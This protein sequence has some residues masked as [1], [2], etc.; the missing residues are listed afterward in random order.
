MT[1]QGD[2]SLTASQHAVLSLSWT[3]EEHAYQG[4]DSS[5]VHTDYRAVRQNLLDIS[6]KAYL[7][8]HNF[9]IC[10]IVLPNLENDWYYLFGYL[11][12]GL[13]IVWFS[14]ALLCNK[15]SGIAHH[16]GY[17]ASVVT[18][19][20]KKKLNKNISSQHIWCTF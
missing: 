15:E 9:V 13:A 5:H 11:Q 1:L 16:F 19:M 3:Q 10:Y 20:T 8:M 4:Y 2:G 17:L 6:Q 14:T 7:L 12:Q 18:A